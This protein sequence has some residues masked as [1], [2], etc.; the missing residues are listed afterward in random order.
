MIWK[1]ASGFGSCAGG[2]IC[3]WAGGREQ[4]ISSGR[5]NVHCNTANYITQNNNGWFLLL[6]FFSIWSNFLMLSGHIKGSVCQGIKR[7]LFCLRKYNRQNSVIIIIII[8]KVLPRS[9]LEGAGTV[10]H[11]RYTGSL[12]AS[13]VPSF[14]SS[15]DMLMN[16]CDRRQETALRKWADIQIGLK[17][18]E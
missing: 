16:F 7:C 4:H 12:K 14:K 15:A 18:P 9:S 17:P 13:F 6:F 2:D 11:S 10:Q 5:L 8:K 1:G 3:R